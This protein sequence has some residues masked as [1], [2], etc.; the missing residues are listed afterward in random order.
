M[1]II[2][3]PL[4]PCLR[5]DKG[6]VYFAHF[7]G[8]CADGPPYEK[9]DDLPLH[10]ETIFFDEITRRSRVPELSSIPGFEINS[11]SFIILFGYHC[12]PPRILAGLDFFREGRRLGEEEWKIITLDPSP[13]K[14]IEGN[15]KKSE[16]ILSSLSCRKGQV[17]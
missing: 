14:R 8:T 17:A 15:R 6:A 4:L 7:Y 5:I 16:R 1:H 9:K 11:T 12:C 2:I 13:L 3:P 10:R